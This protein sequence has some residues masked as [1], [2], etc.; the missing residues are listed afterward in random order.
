MTHTRVDYIKGIIA[1]VEEQGKKPEFQA[2]ISHP[3]TFASE[4][5]KALKETAPELAE[6]VGSLSF[7]EVR[8]EGFMSF[9]VCFDELLGK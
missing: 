6:K 4:M 1:E 8:R 2:L 5:C 9:L 3:Q 7:E